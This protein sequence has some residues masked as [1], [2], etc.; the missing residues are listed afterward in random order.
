MAKCSAERPS[1]ETI[2]PHLLPQSLNIDVQLLAEGVRV[3]E[4]KRVS[5]RREPVDAS[6]YSRRCLRLSAMRV[7]ASGKTA[8][9]SRFSDGRQAECLASLNS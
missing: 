1:I 9:M 6:E 3:E 4:V 2:S 8:I 5:G 7:R